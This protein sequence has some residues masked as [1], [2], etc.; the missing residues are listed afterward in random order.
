VEE[1]MPKEREALHRVSFSIQGKN[2]QDAV[3]KF[4]Q[5][6][7][8]NARAKTAETEKVLAG[9]IGGL[10]P[11]VSPKEFAKLRTSLGSKWLNGK[12]SKV[13]F[14]LSRQ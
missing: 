12:G 8:K 11:Y 1:V 7:L 2:E 9:I 13:R 10:E 14:L 5:R 3:L 4:A 6:I